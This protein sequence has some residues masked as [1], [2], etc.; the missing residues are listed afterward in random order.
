MNAGANR[1]PRRCSTG[2]AVMPVAMALA[3]LL[4]TGCATT[5]PPGSSGQPG[6]SGTTSAGP[7][8]YPSADEG[9]VRVTT[10]GGVIVLDA[11][12]GARLCVGMVLDSYP[13]QCG[14]VLLDGWD[15][16]EHTAGVE[17]AGST[18]WG[19]FVVTGEYDPRAGVM[20]DVR[21]RA[22]MPTSTPAAP[23]EGA[24]TFDFTAPCPAPVGGWAVIDDGSLGAE[25]IDAAVVAAGALPDASAVW[26]DT[27]TLRDASES[28]LDATAPGTARTILVVR[29]TDDAGV[30]AAR[31]RIRDLWGGPLCVTAGGGSLIARAEIAADPP[32]GMLGAGA[33]DL[34][35]VVDVSV[36]FDDG[37]LQRA[38]DETYGADTVRVASALVPAT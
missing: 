20:R 19:T 18:T 2:S 35:D 15:W 37:A 3:G 29:V 6:A 34:N 12:Q 32:V 17:R 25:A 10:R 21:G 28:D 1:H 14:D 5:V 30:A 16:S 4:L 31:E 8:S 24:K 33:D 11:G 26:V 22:W 23:Q 7:V 13:P 27:D 38:Y 36:I 9:A